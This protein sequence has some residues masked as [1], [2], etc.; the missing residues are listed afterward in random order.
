MILDAA[1]FV[2]DVGAVVSGVV[3]VTT[4]SGGDGSEQRSAPSQAGTVKG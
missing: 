1:R 4:N 2:G 3:G